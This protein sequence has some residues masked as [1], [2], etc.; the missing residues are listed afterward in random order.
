MYNPAV[1]TIIIIIHI[2]S[3]SSQEDDP[4]FLEALLYFLGLEERVYKCRS[5]N[6]V[7]N[8][9]TLVLSLLTFAWSESCFTFMWFEAN[10][11]V[12]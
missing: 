7:F 11:A 10:L 3:L 4:S 2:F 9:H 1:Y 6:E 5:G 8:T 12:I